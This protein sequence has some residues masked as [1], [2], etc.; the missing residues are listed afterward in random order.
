MSRKKHLIT[1]FPLWESRKPDG[2]EK[3]FIRLAD[4]M[5]VSD[6][7]L[8]LPGNAFKVYCFMRLESAGR[9]Q[10]KFPRNKYIAYM[11]PPT[12]FKA[13]RELEE[14][15]II[16]VLEHNANLRKANLYQFSDRWKDYTDP[17]KKN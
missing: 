13:V 5:M 6:A 3:R 15:G 7:V 12:F 4:T 10:F 2:V 1:P 8:H 17:G 14:R 9:R 11:S 16:D